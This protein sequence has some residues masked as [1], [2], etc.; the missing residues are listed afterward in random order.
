M[1]DAT[2][3]P[4]HIEE[5]IE[6][7]ARLN[8]DHAERATPFQRALTAVSMALSQPL[9]LALITGA[10]IVW[11]AANWFAPRFGFAPWDPPPFNGLQG[12]LA[13]T[14]VYM[15]AIILGA[16]R[17]AD[18]LSGLRE[19]LTLELAILGEQKTA[20]VIA[21]MEEMRRD[22]PLLRNRTDAE[23]DAMSAPSDPGAVIVA[24]QDKQEAAE[25]GAI[26][27]DAAGAAS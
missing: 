16:Q 26:A 13:L 23:A 3:L 11:L 19:Q 22:N 7:I 17:R 15:T 18:Q 1:D 14:A 9:F 8:A 12:A 20:K 6:A 24:L 4:P 21:L 27:P 25:G 5:T 10:V 2:I